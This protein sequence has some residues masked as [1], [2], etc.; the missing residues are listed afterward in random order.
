MVA[1]ESSALDYPPFFGYFSYLLTI[2]ARLIPS[3]YAEHLLTISPTPVEGW[4]ITAY[5]RLSVLC[6]EVVL[7]AGLLR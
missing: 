4:D 2:P 6:T 7:C 5:M 3:R 1:D